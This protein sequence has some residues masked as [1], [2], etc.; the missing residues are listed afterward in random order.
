MH[1]RWLVVF[2][3]LALP[4]ATSAE[5]S[6]KIQKKLDAA[7][8]AFKAAVEKADNTRFYAVQKATADRIKA[9]KLALTDATKSG[10]FDGATK[11]KELVGSAEAGSVRSKPKDLVKF[12]GHEYAVVEDKL[13]WYYAK[14][15]C[16]EMGGHLVTFESAQEQEFVLTMCRDLKRNAWIGLSNEENLKWTW[17]SGKAAQMD[18]TWPLDN[19]ELGT[20]AG[21]MMYWEP[22]RTFTDYQLGGF[23]G[24]VCEWEK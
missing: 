3:L 15:R 21:S 16:E 17:I 8:V 7:E 13:T 18:P 9:L 19:P 14:R 10:D 24:Y 12:G 5:L 6:E 23:M 20:V 4:I 22:Y 1:R 11:I 2:L